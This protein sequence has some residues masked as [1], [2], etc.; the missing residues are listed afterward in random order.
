M[1][2]EK[3][4]EIRTSLQSKRR[5]LVDQLTEMDISD[6]KQ[7]AST[8]VPKSMKSIGIDEDLF[9]YFLLAQLHCFL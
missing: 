7:L 9:S 8:V 3:L 6:D 2:K 4:E 1:L 5:G